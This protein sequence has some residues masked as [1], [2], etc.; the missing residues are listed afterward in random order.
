M[1][2]FNGSTNWLA[3]N[4]PIT[5]QTLYAVMIRNTTGD[6][7]TLMSVSGPSTNPPGNIGYMM[8]GDKMWTGNN[9]DNP[10]LVYMESAGSLGNNKVRIATLEIQNGPAS[11]SKSFIDGA[12]FPM[13]QFLGQ[14]S[15]MGP[16]S[17]T[18][19]IGRAQSVTDYFD[20]QVAELIMYPAS[21]TDAERDLVQSYLAVKYGIQLVGN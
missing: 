18:P 14:G 11:N 1:V 13:S 20:G 21:H 3:G 5:F 16:F 15:T 7:G 17:F 2:D 19:Y 8:K 4:T 9:L 10:N 12:P 6:A